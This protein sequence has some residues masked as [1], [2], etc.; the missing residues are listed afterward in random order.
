MHLLLYA[1]PSPIKIPY[2]DEYITI[3]PGDI[4]IYI[5]ATVFGN[6]V[7]FSKIGF[8]ITIDPGLC[9][10]YDEVPS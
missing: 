6:L 10:R 1:G 9:R 5:K 3:D 7:Y 4:G 8:E 2:K